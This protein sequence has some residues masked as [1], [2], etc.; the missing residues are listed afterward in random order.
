MGIHFIQFFI[1]LKILGLK[2]LVLVYRVFTHVQ[3]GNGVGKKIS[4][5][6]V[7]TTLGQNIL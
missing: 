4:L 1:D 3:S 7:V 6:V 5:A 2:K